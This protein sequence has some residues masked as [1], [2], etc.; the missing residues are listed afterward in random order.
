VDWEPLPLLCLPAP[1]MR[2]TVTCKSPKIHKVV[3]FSFFFLVHGSVCFR[4][5]SALFLVSPSSLLRCSLLVA[6]PAMWD[7]VCG[8]GAG[9]GRCCCKG[10]GPSL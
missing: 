8:G 7:G 2:V 5:G 3:G 1:V 4:F 9:G 10:G 6:G